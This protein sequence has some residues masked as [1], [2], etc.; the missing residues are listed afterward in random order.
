MTNKIV[1]VM[2][3]PADRQESML[4]FGETLFAALAGT[5]LNVL[6]WQPPIIFGKLP[7][8]LPKR[9]MKWLAYIDK[10]GLGAL[11]LLWLRLRNPGAIWHVVDHGN[12]MYAGLLPAGRTLIT[13]HDCIAI[14]DAFIG[15]TG[16]KIGR[17]GRVFQHL[18]CSGLRHVR[19]IA[20]V[21]QTTA[22]DLVRLVHPDT[23]RIRI[24][25]NGLM[26]SL[27][28]PEPDEAVRKLRLL[29]VDGER[30][31]IFM[32]GSDLR[33]KNRL[34]ALRCF[35]LLRADK[36]V[37]EFQ[38]VFAGKPMAGENRAAADVSPWR[39]DIIEIGRIDNST[40]AA[41]YRHAAVVLFPSLAEG[42][43]LPII[44]AQTCG[45][46]LVTSRRQ[47][48]AEIAGDGAVL[49]DP[50]N[51]VEMAACILQAHAE[52]DILRRKG[53]A[54]AQRFT[55][56]KMLDG[57]LSIYRTLGETE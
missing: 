33:R 50:E 28:L 47:P 52:G 25:Y 55:L 27:C 1:L 16:Q 56:E 6:A 20:C 57:Y 14:E 39:E 22:D 46:A 3:Y 43:G 29:G 23:A 31:F 24:V 26:Q 42:F 10:F 30:P 54:N 4:R 48:M 19:A 8:F 34:N 41:A 9:T 45:A 44:E 32:I 13:C 35:D 17:F 11:S 38:L 15:R 18:I 40:L 5:G 37:P 49:V 21:S 12:A 2:N 53:L 51:P 7:G 36:T